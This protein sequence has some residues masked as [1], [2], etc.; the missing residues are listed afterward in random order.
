MLAPV[1]VKV[2]VPL[3][4]SVRLPVPSCSTP[5]KVVVALSPSEVN[6]AA[7]PVLV[8]DPLPAKEPIELEKPLRFKVAPVITVKSELVLRPVAEPACKI[9]ALTVVTPL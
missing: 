1:K 9:P 5:L 7:A 6:V 8:T 3:F 2:P 4:T